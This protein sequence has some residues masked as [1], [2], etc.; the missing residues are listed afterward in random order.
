MFFHAIILSRIGWKVTKTKSRGKPLREWS[1]VTQFEDVNYKRLNDKKEIRRLKR[2]K[3]QEFS[4][5]DEG[6]LFIIILI[7]KLCDVC[8]AEPKGNY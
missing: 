6:E 4:G 7:S 5:L 8:F 3:S 1:D 2:S